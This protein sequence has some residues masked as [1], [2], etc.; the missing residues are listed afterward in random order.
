MRRPMRKYYEMVIQDTLEKL[1]GYALK[2]DAIL[3]DEG[4]DFSDDMLRIVVALLNPATNHLAIALD[5][6][7]NIYQRRRSW[8]ELGIQARGRVHRVTRVYR[9]TQ[10]IA[11]FAAALL[12]NGAL[13]PKSADAPG[14]QGRLFPETFEAAHGAPPNIRAFP[15]YGKIAAWVA[16]KI[17]QLATEEGYPL[18]EIAVL[19]AMK[20][21]END[22]ALSL[23]LLIAKALDKKGLLHNWISEDY[24]AKRSY[25]VTTDSVTISTIH[26]V[27]GFDYACVFLLGLDWLA[28]GV[29]WSEEQIRKLV[30]VAV[31]RARER[32][33][34]PGLI[35]D[36]FISHITAVPRLIE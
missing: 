1:P 35:G 25:D 20:T 19:Y 24:R 30:Y 33:F 10:E 8:K 9:N 12:G 5:E 28:P 16:G 31:T 22:H 29:R 27:T 26:S 13:A 17:R 6:N 34:I 2:Y 21:P 3:V 18:S 23:P 32:L 4:Q 7:Q 14:R 36:G 15:D 11:D